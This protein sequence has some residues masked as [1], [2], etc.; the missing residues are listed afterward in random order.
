MQHFNAGLVEAGDAILRQDV[1]VVP[2][3]TVATQFADFCQKHGMCYDATLHTDAVFCHLK[4]RG[5]LGLNPHNVHLNAAKV[6]RVGANLKELHGAW[7]FEFSGVAAT[8]AYQVA[9]NAALIDGAGG[10]LAKPTGSERV[11]SMGCGHTAAACRA[12][13]A[14]CRITCRS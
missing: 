6:H 12:A 3:I 1:M 13:N 2:V 4:N 14:G 10:L 5:G 9:F 8:K 7:A 11:L